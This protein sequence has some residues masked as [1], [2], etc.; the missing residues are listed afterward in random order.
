MSAPTNGSTGAT[1]YAD[2]ARDPSLPCLGS[3]LRPAIERAKRRASGEEKPIPLPLPSLGEQFAGGLWPGV[4]FLNAGTGVG[5]TQLAM[6]IAL[7]AATCG[8][9]VAYVGLE[10]VELEIALRALGLAGGVPWAHL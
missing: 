4:H 9:P 2:V 8:V 3:L 5:K 1:H 10:L 7:H 6:Q